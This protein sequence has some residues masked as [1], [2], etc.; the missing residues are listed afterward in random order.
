MYLC[1]LII[2]IIPHLERGGHNNQ[3]ERSR[4]LGALVAVAALGLCCGGAQLHDSR[5]D[6]WQEGSGGVNGAE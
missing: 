3:L 4:R 1:F 6:A 2:I 5:E